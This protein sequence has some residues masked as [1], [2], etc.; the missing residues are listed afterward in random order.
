M[1][2]IR[3]FLESTIQRMT[4][5]CKKR[6]PP[7]L[8]SIF[9]APAAA[10]SSFAAMEVSNQFKQVFKVMDANGDGKISPLELSDM[11]SCLGYKK[12]IATMEAEGISR[13][14]D[15]NGDGFLDL[16][17]FITA[18]KVDRSRNNSNNVG[19]GE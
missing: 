16:D 10:T 11:L 5:G 14:M 1:S 6:K 15:F 4:S 19:F 8:S 18:V 17:E 9:D 7:K 13:E 12:S 2:C 3:I